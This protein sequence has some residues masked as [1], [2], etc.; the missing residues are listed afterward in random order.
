MSPSD[1]FAAHGGSGILHDDDAPALT[2]TSTIFNAREEILSSVQSALDN[3]AANLLDLSV[4]LVQPWADTSATEIAGNA[5]PLSTLNHLQRAAFDIIYQALTKRRTQQLIM[6]LGGEGGTGK[7]RVISAILASAQPKSC[8]VTATTGVAATNFEGGMTIHMFCGWSKKKKKN[9]ARDLS[10]AERQRTA[11]VNL[12][13]IDEISMQGCCFLAGTI[14]SA[15]QRLFENEH[16]FGGIHIVFCGDFGQLPPIGDLPLYK[17]PHSRYLTNDDAIAGHTIWRN[18]LNECIILEENM[19]A[20][21]DLVFR[22]I[23]TR[24][25][26]GVLTDGDLELLNSRYIGPNAP[27]LDRFPPQVPVVTPYNSRRHSITHQVLDQADHPIFLL[28]AT[29]VIR[30]NTTAAALDSL[31]RLGDEKTDGLPPLLF[32]HS[33][34][35]IMVSKNKWVP[36]GIANGTLG[37]IEEIQ[38]P[39]HTTFTRKSI[40]QFNTP[41]VVF[42]PSERPSFIW[43]SFPSLPNLPRLSCL[44]ASISQH[45]F[46]FEPVSA[47]ISGIKMS[48]FPLVPAFVRSVHKFQGATEERLVID[49]FR[50]QG[51]RYTPPTASLYVSLSRCRSLNGLILH[52]RLSRDLVNYFKPDPE[53]VI[54]ETRLS[55]L[56]RNSLARLQI[57][58]GYAS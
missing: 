28:A 58:R 31:F 38:F 18:A 33:K 46:P 10:D 24:A 26:Q 20:A 52:Q 32:V 41:L 34:M 17:A 49:S 9:H 50:L 22:G 5:D 56:H 27:F 16:L 2:I 53:L 35:P 47:T 48:Q 55:Q 25:R 40:S 57:S 54:E 36:L 21:A 30:S 51:L 1:L 42:Q 8:V 13:I 4:P 6:Y 39:E 44:P 3:A 37:I 15:F 19:R 29:T 12:V 7:S 43:C 11:G 45:L 23:L 14:N